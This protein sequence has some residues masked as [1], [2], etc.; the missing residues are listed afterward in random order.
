[1]GR[2]SGLSFRLH[3]AQEQARGDAGSGSCSD[4]AERRRFRGCAQTRIDEISGGGGETHSCDRRNPLQASQDSICRRG[5]DPFT[6]SR[7]FCRPWKS[8]EKASSQRRSK[9]TLGAA[10]LGV[11]GTYRVDPERWPGFVE[12][13]GRSSTDCQVRLT[14]GR[15]RAPPLTLIF[16]LQG[17]GTPPRCSGRGQAPLLLRR[18]EDFLAVRSVGFGA[19]PPIQKLSMGSAVSKAAPQ[20]LRIA[21]TR[22]HSRP[23]RCRRSSH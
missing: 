8:A 7:F 16:P 2:A 15:R 12:R 11:P 9:T 22:H 6:R 14:V 1:M 13:I 10:A 20:R 23:S 4:P 19:V 21:M 5:A 3:R 18:P 17:I